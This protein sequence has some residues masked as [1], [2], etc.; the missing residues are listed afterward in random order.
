VP[1]DYYASEPSSG[2][3]LRTKRNACRLIPDPLHEHAATVLI[4]YAPPYL[5]AAEYHYFRAQARG[6]RQAS[7]FAGPTTKKSARAHRPEH[8]Q[9][10]CAE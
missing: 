10:D 1:I 7:G 4:E 6:V 8:F 9:P 3:S 2:S 5:M